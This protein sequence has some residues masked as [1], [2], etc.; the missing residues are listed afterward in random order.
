M[1]AVEKAEQSDLS[2]ESVQAHRNRIFMA[3]DAFGKPDKKQVPLPNKSTAGNNLSVYLQNPVKKIIKRTTTVERV[4]L[5]KPEKIQAAKGTKKSLSINSKTGLKMFDQ[6][7]M[8][9]SKGNININTEAKVGVSYHHDSLI[10]PQKGAG[11]HL[12]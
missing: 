8:M 9:S 2:E 1:K 11:N 6:E 12:S 10:I 5:A 4:N 3:N 7:S